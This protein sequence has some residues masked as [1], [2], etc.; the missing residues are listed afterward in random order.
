[1]PHLDDAAAL[2]AIRAQRRT[3]AT[4]MTNDPE[5]SAWRN[6]M[7]ENFAPVSAWLA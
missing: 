2:D 5:L 4:T 7:E 1:M 6:R 3:G